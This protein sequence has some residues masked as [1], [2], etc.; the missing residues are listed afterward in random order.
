ME[1]FESMKEVLDPVELLDAE[2][3]VVAGGAFL[4]PNVNCITVTTPSAGPFRGRTIQICY[5]TVG[6]GNVPP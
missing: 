3:A 2:L 4:G 1:T 5:A 6:P